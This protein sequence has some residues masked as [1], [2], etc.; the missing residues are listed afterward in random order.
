WWRP[1]T[2]TAIT[3]MLWLSMT[4]IENYQ[5][6]QQLDSMNNEI[7]QDFHRGLPQQTVIIDAMAQLRQAANL[8][9]ANNSNSQQVTQQ[10]NMISAAFKA[11][12]WQMQELRINGNEVTISGKVNSLDTLNDISNALQKELGKKVKITDTD[13]NG[14]E[15]SFRMRWT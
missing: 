14:N 7:I 15:V 10:L 4:G 5:L 11:H 1:I 13:L 12:P 6:R 8:G 9:G 2:L 3:C